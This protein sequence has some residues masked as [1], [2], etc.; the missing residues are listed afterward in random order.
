MAKR[1]LTAIVFVLAASGAEAAQCHA[2]PDITKPGSWAWQWVESRICWYI[3]DANAPKESLHW[4]AP[5]QAAT[6]KARA[7]EPAAKRAAPKN[8]AAS[9]EKLSCRTQPEGAGRWRWRTVEGRQC[10][11]IGARDTP[12]DALHWPSER[13]RESS[14]ESADGAAVRATDHA[15]IRVKTVEVAAAASS[16]TKLAEQ[17]EDS[18]ATEHA[19]HAEL[20]LPDAA[21]APSA[22]ADAQPWQLVNLEA[23]GDLEFLAIGERVPVP[24]SMDQRV[25]TEFLTRTPMAFWPPLARTWTR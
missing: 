2:L 17:P 22:L 4:N 24:F 3:G 10:W 13:K 9:G 20:D 18:G 11:F 14:I 21:A 5:E 19:E 23:G 12:K 8:T 6:P 1:I 15:P 7:T 16:A 25:G